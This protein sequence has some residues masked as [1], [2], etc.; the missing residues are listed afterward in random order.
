VLAYP[1]SCQASGSRTGGPCIRSLPESGQAWTY[2]VQRS[3]GSDPRQYVLKRLKNKERL[4]RFKNEIEALARLSHPGVLK[5]VEVGESGGESYFVA[6]YCDRGDLSNLDLFMRMS[7]LEKLKLFREICDAVAAAHQAKIVHRDIKHKNVLVKLD[8]SI[9]VADFGLCLDLDDMEERL[10]QTQ[11]AVGS[12]GYIA[13]EL[14]DGRDSTPTTAS[15]CFSLG[16]LLFYLLAGRT[17]ART[18]YRG[19]PHDL[20]VPSS[21]GY[22]ELVY[23]DLFPKTITESATGRFQNA[24]EL[25][26]AVDSVIM[27]IEQNAHVFE[28]TSSAALPL[29]CCWRIPTYDGRSS[30]TRVHAGVSQ[31]RKYTEILKHAE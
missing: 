20:R 12:R 18:N 21:D 24:W 30:G 23:S 27:R 7:L 2:V 31:L 28:S 29:L 10:T 19:V 3:N 16:K 4:G 22:L 11:E 13:P 26:D 9:A 25:R 17:L 8:G 6:E 15:D 5:L 1:Q 14:E